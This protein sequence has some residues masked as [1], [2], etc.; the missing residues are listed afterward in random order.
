MLGLCVRFS[1][2]PSIFLLEIE[3]D[4]DDNDPEEDD[5]HDTYM[6]NEIEFGRGPLQGDSFNISDGGGR[7]LHSPIPSGEDEVKNAN[8]AH[9]KGL[10]PIEY[11]YSDSTRLLPEGYYNLAMGSKC[12]FTSARTQ[13]F[14]KMVF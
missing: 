12:V 8:V 11:D 1:D 2:N 5:E 13:S 10:E 14:P 4:I 6:Y 3:A 7:M 9:M